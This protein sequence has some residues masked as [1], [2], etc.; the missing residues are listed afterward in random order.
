MFPVENL[1]IFPFFYMEKLQ[2]EKCHHMDQLTVQMWMANP[3][4]ICEKN[5]KNDFLCGSCVFATFTFEGFLGLSNERIFAAIMFV[6]AAFFLHLSCAC[7]SGP[8]LTF[9]QNFFIIFPVQSKMFRNHGKISSTFTLNF[10]KIFPHPEIY[11]CKMYL[12]F[13]CIF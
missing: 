13:S 7:L 11:F 8:S 10:L 1:N 5:T 9:L 4:V 2:C 3:F 12:K 6:A